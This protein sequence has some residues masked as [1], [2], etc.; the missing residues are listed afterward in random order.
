M[1]IPP[2][3]ARGMRYVLFVV[4]SAFVLFY[5]PPCSHFIYVL[6]S[7]YVRHPVTAVVPLHTITYSYYSYYYICCTSSRANGSY[8][9]LVHRIARNV[10]HVG[11]ELDL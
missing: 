5:S 3:F 8:G 4:C 10:G 7:R 11:P 9:G 2:L 1:C 6:V